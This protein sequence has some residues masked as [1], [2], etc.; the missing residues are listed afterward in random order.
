AKTFK[1]NGTV[2]FFLLRR[3]KLTRVY[4]S[5]FCVSMCILYVVAVIFCT[6]YTPSF[7]D[8]QQIPAAN[9]ILHCQSQGIKQR[10]LLLVPPAWRLAQQHLPNGTYDMLLG[11]EFF[12]KRDQVFPCFL[13]HRLHL[14]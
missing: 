11:D 6:F 12:L 9:N 1:K 4:H 13:L 7:S 2:S 14:I 10:D 8:R 5:Y 3:C